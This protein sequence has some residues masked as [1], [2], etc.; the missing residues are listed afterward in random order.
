MPFIGTISNRFEKGGTDDDIETILK[1]GAATYE[2]SSDG[3][4]MTYRLAWVL[5]RS[6]Y[7][8]KRPLGEQIFG[9]GLITDSYSKLPYHF[10][11]GIYYKETGQAAQMYT[12]D[13]SYGNLLVHWGFGGI[14]IYMWFVIAMVIFLIRNRKENPFV[15]TCAALSLMMIFISFAGD[16]L[17]APKNFVIFFIVLSTLGQQHGFGKSVK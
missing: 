14:I 4:T 7:L 2:S 17:S 3:G 5:E 9:L 6:Y 16:N 1:G 10:L 13:I 12:P 15:T 8:M 11:L